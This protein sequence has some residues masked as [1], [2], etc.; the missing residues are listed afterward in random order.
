MRST[1]AGLHLFLQ[2]QRWRRCICVAFAT[3]RTSKLPGHLSG[4]SAGLT[5]LQR[6]ECRARVALHARIEN[7]CGA[8]ALWKAFYCTYANSP[9]FFGSSQ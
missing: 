7:A 5:A 2:F 3:L 8:A 9:R 1:D 6:E 4:L